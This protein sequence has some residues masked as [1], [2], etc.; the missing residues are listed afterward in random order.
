MDIETNP[1]I[2]YLDEAKI[3]AGVLIPILKTLRAELGNEH[4]NQLVLGALRQW[5]REKTHHSG[6]LIPGSPI[7]KWK[8]L[9]DS[10]LPRIGNDANFQ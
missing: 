4:A 5:L 2:S 8:A 10:S 6:A 1:N 9:M 3:Q 7:D